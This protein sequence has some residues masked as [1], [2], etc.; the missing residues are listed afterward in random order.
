MTLYNMKKVNGE[1][2]ITKFD[3]HLNVESSYLTSPEACECPAGHRNTCRHRQML[4]VFIDNNKVNTAW[5]L[6]WEKGRW[7]NPFWPAWRRL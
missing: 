3:E 2:R 6:D 7:T 1:Y 5:C 4:P